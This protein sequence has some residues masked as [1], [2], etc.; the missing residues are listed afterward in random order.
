MNVPAHFLPAPVVYWQ[1]VFVSARKHGNFCDNLLL[2]YG[3]RKVMKNQY[4]TI[5]LTV[6]LMVGC[7]ESTESGAE[8]TQS[9][10]GENPV[11]SSS[12]N[13]TES[14]ESGAESTQPEKDE[15]P[16]T[17]SSTIADDDSVAVEPVVEIDEGKAYLH[18]N[19]Q[20]PAVKVLESGL[21]FEILKSGTGKTP[22]LTSNVVT[23]YHGTLTNGEVFDSSV[24]R[25]KPAEFPVNRVI[26][27]WTEALQMMKEGD[28]WRLVIPPHL[29][30]GERGAAGGKI[31]PNTVLIFEVELIKVKE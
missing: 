9:G 11:S 26:A 10:K 8:S 5:L 23:H 24:E 12:A 18:I 3:W 13:R 27:G 4:L 31:P 21:Q 28:K 7:S 25:G 19:A 14:G 17:S 20:N 15:N 16:V 29:G 6:F 22:G 30:Y 1:V 2:F